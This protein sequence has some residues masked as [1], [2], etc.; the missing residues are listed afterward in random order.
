M[1]RLDNDTAGYL[2]FAKDKKIFDAYKTQQDAHQIYKLYLCDVQGQVDVERTVAKHPELAMQ[3]L[4]ARTQAS[5]I[6]VVNC[7]L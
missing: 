6:D 3:K 2:Y 5:E 1:N 4:E 7:A